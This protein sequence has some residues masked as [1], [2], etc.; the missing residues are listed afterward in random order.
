MKQIESTVQTARAEN[1]ERKQPAIRPVM[2][3][4]LNFFKG[5]KKS[6]VVKNEARPAEQT[7]RSTSHAEKGTAE[8]TVNTIN[9]NSRAEETSP[10]KPET[11]LLHQSNQLSPQRTAAPNVADLSTVR[12][13]S[14]SPKQR[15][16][17]KLVSSEN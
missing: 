15:S 6:D 17:P 12:S 11:A 4:L 16:P 1:Q 7:S 10:K 9:K 13:G 14:P 2:T 5:S 3:A 8:K